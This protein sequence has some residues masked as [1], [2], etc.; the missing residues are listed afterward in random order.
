MNLTLGD[1]RLI[2]AACK[3]EGLLRNQAAYVLATAYHETAHTM[4]P[5]REYGGET[6]LKKKPYYPYVG[7]GYVQLTWL[8]NYQKASKKLGV[9]FV[10]NPRLLLKAE[11]AAQI[12]VIGSRDGWFTGKKLAD[13]ITISRSDF[14]GAR[15]I[16][17]GTDRAKL[18]ADIAIRY[19]A[20]LKQDG[21]GEDGATKFKT[22]MPGSAPSSVKVTIPATGGD[23]GNATIPS[24]PA[25]GA[26]FWAQLITA[27][28]RYFSKG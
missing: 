2:I 19:D 15:K 3:K 18:I 16:I 14:T 9:D 12:L 24:E 23:K 25:K 26:S 20:L 11:Y 5:V 28:L 17:N 13:Y 27:I 8:A 22:T 1:T 21:Y 6:Y 10:K 4:K 7:M